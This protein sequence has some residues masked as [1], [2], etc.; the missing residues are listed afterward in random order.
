MH[1]PRIV[2]GAEVAE[3]VEVA[4]LPRPRLGPLA[5]AA[6]RPRLHPRRRPPRRVHQERLRQLDLP[7]LLEEPERE[8]GGDQDPAEPR[9]AATGRRQ[10][11]RAPRLAAG[12][13]A[14]DVRLRARRVALDLPERQRERAEA[15]LLVAREQVDLHRLAGDRLPRQRPPHRDP[16]QRRLG[17]H[18]REDEQREL[19][20]E[21]EVEEVVAGVDRR[22][23]DH[24][25]ERQV[26]PAVAGDALLPERAPERAKALARRRHR[27]SGTGIRSTRSASSR[28]VS[29]RSAS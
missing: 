3:R 26:E 23:A 10:P 18:A 7:G 8:P 25:R 14:A 5:L 13:D 11:V 27:Y 29:S 15:L 22:D 6:R 19:Q 16:A 24:Q 21:D 20:A 4:A 17:Q 1:L 9:L 12:R 2:A 28:A